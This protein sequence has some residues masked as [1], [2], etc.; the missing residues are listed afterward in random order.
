MN[1][2]RL[3]LALAIGALC[4]GA[5]SYAS[6]AFD[7]QKYSGLAA[8][9][10]ISSSIRFLRKR[11]LEKGNSKLSVGRVESLH[12]SP[13]KSGKLLC[14]SKLEFVQHGVKN[15]RRWLVVDESG[16]FYTQRKHPQMALLEARVE[17]VGDGKESL[18]LAGRGMAGK[19][20]CQKASSSNIRTVRVWSSQIRAIDEGED[21]AQWISEFIGEPTR[22]VR[23]FDHSERIEEFGNDATPIAFQD[24]CPVL[25]ISQESLDDLNKR[26]PNPV[27]MDRFRPTVVVSGLGGP[28]E[29]DRIETVEIG[30]VKYRLM[31]RKTRCS[32]ITVNPKTGKIDSNEPY[33]T[34]ASYRYVRF[35]LCMQ[36][37]N[38]FPNEP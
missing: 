18:A 6:K 8:I 26:L 2:I 37:N 4:L 19:F 1:R 36:S 22:L 10:V 14:S 13:V 28:Y 23:C 27:E 11:Y 24:D 15:D 9:V 29:E 30:N 33:R 3:L 12:Y 31:E 16:D 38:V 21:A 25:L 34:L 20:E 32:L 5:I 35:A 17:Q 7:L